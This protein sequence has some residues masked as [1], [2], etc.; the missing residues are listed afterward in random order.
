ME[1]RVIEE[2]HVVRATHEGV[3][4]AT[5]S[6]VGEREPEALEQGINAK[7][8]EQDQAGRQEQVRRE[9]ASAARAARLHPGLAG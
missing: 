9:G 1:P 2:P 3:L 6:R 8:R 5:E 7:D 4:G